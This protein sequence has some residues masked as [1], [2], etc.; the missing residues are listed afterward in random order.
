[1]CFIHTISTLKVSHD[2]DQKCQVTSMVTVDKLKTVKWVTRLKQSYIGFPN[3][4]HSYWMCNKH[5][6]WVILLTSLHLDLKHLMEILVGFHP[7]LLQAPI[8][9]H[10]HEVI[11]SKA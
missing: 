5:Y 3:Q 11:P 1:M 2:L 6:T 9:L 8:T 4:W 10:Q 7:T